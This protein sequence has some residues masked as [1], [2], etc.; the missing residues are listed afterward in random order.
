MTGFIW[1]FVAAVKRF[2][3]MYAALFAIVAAR[4]VYYKILIKKT[5]KEI[6][7]IEEKERERAEKNAPKWKDAP[8]LM[9]VSVQDKVFGQDDDGAKDASE[10]PRARAE[11]PAEEVE[12]GERPGRDGARSRGG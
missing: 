1:G 5:V 9:A 11:A 12:S 10:N 7:K 6:E 2:A 4:G 3:W 8:T